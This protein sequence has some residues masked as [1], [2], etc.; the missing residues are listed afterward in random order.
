M[1]FGV[2][3]QDAIGVQ[4]GL[5]AMYRHAMTALRAGNIAG[6]LKRFV[7]TSRQRYETIFYSLGSNLSDAVDALGDIE[8]VT[9]G[10]DWAELLLIRD[11]D[12]T[13]TGYRINVI[14][15][16]DGVWRIEEM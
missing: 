11:E 13:R 4:A 8:N 9:V 2:M 1:T 14:R 6:A 10:D 7:G 3:A 5:R 12:G 16:E 15:G